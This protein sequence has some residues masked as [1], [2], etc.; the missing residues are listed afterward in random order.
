[1]K[2]EINKELSINFENINSIF[3]LPIAYNNKVKKLDEN[4]VTELELTNSIDK[5][6][7]SIYHTIF[8]PTNEATK[9]ILE[10]LTPLYTTDT[11]FLK[12]TQNIINNI[13][14]KDLNTIDNKYGY[15]EDNLGD[16][17]NIYKEIKN[18]TA[19]CEK[20]LY[21]D[22]TFAKHLNNNPLFLQIMSTYNI[23]SPILSLCIP[24]IV[25][26]LPFF[27]IKLT[28]VKLTINQYTDILKGII[29]NH[30]LYKVFTQFNQVDTNQKIYLG[31]S[32][33]LYLFSIYQNILL[34]IRF[35]TNMQKIH[36]YL[37]NIKKYIQY[38]CEHISYYK[39]ISSNFVSY[40]SFKDELTHHQHIL[41]QYL[42]QINNICTFDFS[43]YNCSQIGNIMYA[44]YQIY[45][46]KELNTSIIYSFGFNAYVSIIK[47]TNQLIID[48]KINKALFI[49]QK[50]KTNA[51]KPKIKQ[52][53]YPKYIHSDEKVIKNNYNLN[54][55]YIITGPNASGKT[56]TIKSAFINI[57]LSQ[58]IGFGCYETAKIC[59]ISY[60]HSYL[61]I[62]DTSGRDSLFQAEAR[63][64][65]E[66]I[67][68]INENK[69]EMHFCI[70][71]EL[72]SGTNP[73]E[74]V[75]SAY[76]FLDY[77]CKRSNI[78]CMLTTHYLDLCDKLK[79]KEY[80]KNYY[81]ESI[82]NNDQK[83]INK[84]IFYTY[85]IKKGISSIK[86]GFQVLRNM[87]YPK[88]LLDVF[89]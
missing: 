55:N 65:K 40:N 69:K 16:T 29:S 36:H 39:N 57:L 38:T 77:I 20:Y 5:E 81:M 84:S 52:M 59:P 73:E 21:I 22:W 10:Q 86:G 47:E 37:A 62:P 12:E 54:S 45:D 60:F 49:R 41:L 71:D 51:K 14:Q 80:I 88:E 87:N 75:T 56:T 33:I 25:L 85:K 2:S 46:N 8:N 89:C 4:I 70:F 44:F 9:Y 17:I 50:I 76:S 74:A 78:C 26:I 79:E 19:F 58:Q 83:D 42:N 63:R 48:K 11:Q 64:C 72:Y 18:E 68:C 24:I 23:V 6:E 30:A 1:M 67:E 82:V 7:K 15:R 31:V 34:C 32:S 13:S 53:F 27:I 35:Y 3:K 28:G 61:N 66:I 43:F